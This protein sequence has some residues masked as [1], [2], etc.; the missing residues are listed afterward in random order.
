M[1][2]QRAKAS[3]G[4]V[5]GFLFLFFIFALRIVPDD[6]IL[7]F[8]IGLFCIAPMNQSIM[9]YIFSFVWCLEAVFSFGITFSLIISVLFVLKCTLITQKIFMYKYEF[10]FLLLFLVLGGFN[11]FLYGTLTGIS[12]CVYFYASCIIF[13]MMMSKSNEEAE[14]FFKT[15]L[16][17]ILIGVFEGT[18]YGYIDGTSVLR[19]IPGFG[20]VNQLYG[21]LGTS[22]F[23]LYG[24]IALLYPLYFM[25]KN[26]SKWIVFT[27][28][29]VII[30]LSISLTAIV[31]YVGVIA[32]YLISNMNLKRVPR[33]GV[34]TFFCTIGVIILIVSQLSNI[35]FMEPIM[36]RVEE[37]VTSI[38]EGNMN[39]A[40]TGRTELTDAYVTMF[41]E[42]SFFQKVF[43]KAWLGYDELIGKYSHNSYLDILNYSG[44]VGLLSILF[45]QLKRLKHYYKT[46]NFKVML[47]VKL[48]LLIGATTVSTF[49]AQ[50]WFGL[51]FI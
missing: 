43:G 33:K 15:I 16:F 42:G 29:S 49:S 14:V 7:F 46:N 32:Y 41:K 35:P 38:I 21:T 2:E 4:Y 22:R 36:L 37:M 6:I 26:I 40:T 19:W 5:H 31:L 24:C 9:M 18:V 27:I 50:Y 8:A 34:I 3:Y 13:H 12:I 48:I 20:Y 1:V 10:L 47:I 28:I 44:V 17:M 23:T 30:L 39:D 11:Y 45:V 25:K 51:L